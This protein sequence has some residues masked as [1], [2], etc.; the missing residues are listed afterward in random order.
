[1]NSRCGLSSLSGLFPKVMPPKRPS[2]LQRLSDLGSQRR[3]LLAEAV[4]TLSLVSAGLRL[5]PFRRAIEL[6]DVRARPV[7]GSGGIDD[8]VWA[9][10]AAA[11]RL[12][13]RAVCL[14]KGLT[15]QRMLRRR[16]IDALLDYGIRTDGVEQVLEAHVWVTVDGQAIIGGEEA[17]GFARVARYPRPE[18]LAQ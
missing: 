1:M 17:E 5:L 6:G 12:P 9:I 14:H 11:W 10:E 8:V 3:R 18:P 15:A 7:P 2:L 4:V 13:W 16:G